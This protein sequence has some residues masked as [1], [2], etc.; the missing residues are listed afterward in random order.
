MALGEGEERKKDTYTRTHAPHCV[1]LC[2]RATSRT[3]LPWVLVLCM[4]CR[5]VRL[6]G[7]QS[8]QLRRDGEH[9]LLMQTATAS[10]SC[11]I[12]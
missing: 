6:R 5:L 4:K 8:A 1:G 3:R 9:Y 2:K 12:K 11:V 7:E 10:S